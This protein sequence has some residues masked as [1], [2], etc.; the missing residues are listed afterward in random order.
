MST[1]TIPPVPDET[2]GW[3]F[4]LSC[5]DW[6][7]DTPDPDIQQ[8]AKNLAV[9]TLRMLTAQRVGGCPITVR[10]C[11]ARCGY[12][13]G[14]IYGFGGFKPHINEHGSW[15]NSC[16]CS[17]TGCSC[18]ALSRIILPAPVGRVD[19]VKVDGVTLVKGTDY[20][21]QG[22]DLLRVGAAWP[23]CQNLALEDTEV[24]TMSVTYLRAYQ[25]DYGAAYAA[26]R[27]ACE[28]AKACQGGK[29]A[30]P[31]GVRS[32]TRRGISFEI[33]AD[34]F[35]EGMTGIAPVDAWIRTWNPHGLRTPPRVYS[36]DQVRA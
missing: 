30:L 24:G 1:P 2:C 18:T 19:A 23:T 21:Q 15:V 8:Q 34:T 22:H 5:C 27:L 7:E 10:P 36:I 3:P 9:Q 12:D 4:D 13:A 11:V 31:N 17:P 33:A 29:C 35:S 20:I 14:G 28:Y 32:V 26:G 16:G 25:P 6:T